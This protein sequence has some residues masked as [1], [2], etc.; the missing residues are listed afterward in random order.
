[1]TFSRLEPHS[2]LVN[3]KLPNRLSSHKI[4]SDH[5]II[6]NFT[7]TTFH[8]SQRLDN[9]VT[10]SSFGVFFLLHR[11]HLLHAF[12]D[13]AGRLGQTV[14]L[15]GCLSLHGHC[16]H[17]EVVGLFHWRE[18]H[19]VAS[20]GV[21]VD[22]E[23]GPLALQSVRNTLDG[24]DMNRDPSGGRVRD[25]DSIALL[26]DIDFAWLEVLGVVLL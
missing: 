22:S 19:S 5:Q 13:L 24:V 4:R 21:E 2:I 20:S 10:C 23:E 26:I 9:I 7:S 17:P 3:L 25:Q 1:M 16:L 12:F 11:L 18:F 6:Q 8:K 14:V 15:A